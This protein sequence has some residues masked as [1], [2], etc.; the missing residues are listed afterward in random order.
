MWPPTHPCPG[1]LGPCG[2]NAETQGGHC[3]I[4]ITLREPLAPSLFQSCYRKAEEIMLG[5]DTEKGWTRPRCP[6]GLKMR[7]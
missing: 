4:G 3:A 7:A 6:I 1:L 2:R 5:K